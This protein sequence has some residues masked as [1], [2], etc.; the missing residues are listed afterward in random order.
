MS[1][2][3]KYE[4]VI[5]LEVHA[6]LKTKSNNFFKLNR[7][8]QNINWL[9]K[10]IKNKIIQEYYKHNKELINKIEEDIKQGKISP[11]EAQK[12]IFNS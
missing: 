3:D 8:K 9:H 2:Y 12:L 11:F 7:K 10:T 4:V 6:E 1:K 5:G